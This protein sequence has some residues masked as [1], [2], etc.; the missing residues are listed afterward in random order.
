MK[1]GLLVLF[2]MSQLALAKAPIWGKTGHRV[3]G[4]IAQKHLSRK[5]K[6][7]ICSILEGKSLA[8]VANFADDIKSDTLYNKYYPWHYVNYPADKKYGDQLPSI[9]G[10]IVVAIQT[11]IEKVKNPLTTAAEKTFF[12][13]MLVHFIGDLHQ[14]LHAG[15]AENR[16]GNDI[17]LQ[18]FGNGSNLHRLWDTNLIDHYGMSYT[19]LADNMPGL[20]RKERIELQKGNVLDWVEESHVLANQLYASVENGEKLGYEYSYIY[21]TTVEDQL[22]KGGVRLAGVLNDLFD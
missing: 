20:S 12:L 19:E 7:M 18:W 22:F 15:W 11:C 1:I 16:G 21:W 8:T 4:E 2:F 6:K 5:A 17:Q 3:V 9:E 13:K 10:D 14:P